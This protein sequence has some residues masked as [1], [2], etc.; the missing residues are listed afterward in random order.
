MDMKN[1]RIFSKKIQMEIYKMIQPLPAGH[2]GGSLSAADA[3][4]LLYG[5][6]LKHDPQNP[7]WADRDW[8]VMSK[9]H[10]GPVVY[11]TLALRGFF[12]ME[13]LKTLNNGG[14]YLPSHCDR[15]RT[16]GIDMSTGSLGQGASTAAGVAFGFKLDGAPNK[17]YLMMGDGEINEGQVW[18]MALFASTRKLDNLIMLVDNNKWQIDG[19]TDSDDICNLGDIAGKFE[20]FG[21]SA[22]TVDGH[23]FEAMDKALEIAKNTVGKPSVIVLETIKGY[24]WD[25]IANTAGSHSCG[26]SAQEMADQVAKLEAQIKEI[27]GE[28]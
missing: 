27:E 7:K 2:V 4:A 24:G 16:V 10:C 21:F 11:A 3:L 12:P 22:Q 28:G 8:F 14:T 23:D 5:K 25:K 19:R 1:I 18:E 6:H 20:A 9:G 26:I 17:V 13:Q 15:I